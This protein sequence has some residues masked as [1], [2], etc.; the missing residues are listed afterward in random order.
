[1]SV[2]SADL[3]TSIGKA[4]AAMAVGNNSYEETLALLTGITEITRN[5]S[6]AARGNMS[7]SL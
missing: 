3:A 4:S 7:L 6:K 2:S 1:M 5:G